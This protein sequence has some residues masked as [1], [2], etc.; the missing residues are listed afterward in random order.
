MKE[1]A[2]S[3][4]RANFLEH[5][6]ATENKD[7]MATAALIFAKT[8]EFLATEALASSPVAA[9]MESLHTIPKL[10]VNHSDALGNVS[11]ESLEGF[12]DACKVPADYRSQTALEV[13]R[14]LSGANE[15][16]HPFYDAGRVNAGKTQIKM[17]Q[18]FDAGTQAMIS[19]Q[20][21]Q[22]LESFGE[23]SDRVTTD[24]RLAVALTVLRSHRS[25]I[26]RVLA[27]KAVE[28]PVVLIK[29]PSPEVYNLEQSQNPV[30]ATRYGANRQPM[31]TLYR[32]PDQVNTQPQQIVP[33]KAN[34]NGEPAYLMQNGVVNA[35]VKVNLFDM[36][37][38]ANTVGFSAVDWTDLVSDG[39]AVGTVYIQV[40]Q[41]PVSG[42]NV[43]E[44]YAVQTQYYRNA[45][46]TTMTNA[47]DSGDRIANLRFKTNM[48]AGIQTT[49][50]SASAI[51]AGFTNVNALLDVTFNAN[52]NIKTSYVDGAGAILPSLVAGVGGTITTPNTTTF[53]ELSF[54][55]VGWAP[56]LFFSEENMRKTTAAV[57][58][59]YKE[60]EFIVPVGKNFI[61]DYSL[62]GQEVS[63][64]VT[65]VVSNVIGIGNSARSVSIIQNTLTAVN[66]R[67]AY[68]NANPDIDYYASVA[69]DF[70]AGTLSLPHVG[71]VTLDVTDAAVM[72]ES[73]RL[74]DLHS[75]IT[76]RLTALI[77]D[78]HNKSM[79]TE[80]F[81]AGERARYKVMTSGPIAEV[82]F[83]ITQYW[84]TLD[85]K[86]EVA[87]GSD[88]S[89]KLPNGTQ[90]D[91]IKSNFEVFENTMLIVPVRDA[92]PDDV[93]SFGTVLDRGTFVGQYTPVANGAANKRIVANSR[94]IVFPTN[95][96]GY[97]ITVAGIQAQL[98]VLVDGPGLS[99]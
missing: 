71:V 10:I 54:A 53:G 97:I 34:D 79:Y 83:G 73:E 76:A 99:E 3:K 56:Y 88:Y 60:Q 30:A 15:S 48:T 27:R 18:I 36:T 25:L 1:T 8:H 81:E 43:V 4:F 77:A 91:I 69:Q 74:S 65:N 66:A 82:L 92:K 5:T 6:A 14:I 28:D 24:S 67:L 47:Q 16:V 50:G 42:P 12:L 44:L 58:M 70:A 55:I 17:G 19:G 84:N 59:N 23:Y 57:R 33:L 39:G 51:F 90:L 52:L 7:D 37:L 22:A 96:L 89:L 63:E 41:V 64:D 26:D 32:V 78:G 20:S 49:A 38:Q 13:A 87:E 72:R 9:G 31:V 86:V 29:I 80:S 68:E 40:T 93:T 45:A 21:R 98:E 94:E 2:F 62:M 11:V 95:P 35:G 75:Y 61:V 85:D 46:F